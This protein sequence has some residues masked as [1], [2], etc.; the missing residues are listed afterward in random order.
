MSVL[1][2]DIPFDRWVEHVFDHP[3]LPDRWWFHFDDD[4]SEE[5]NT[6]ANPARTLAFLTR[7]LREPAFLIGKYSRA[8]ID[9]G[10]NYLVDPSCSNHMG[11]IRDEALPLKDRRACIEAMT[12]L[13]SDLMAPVYGNDLG[14]TET[15]PGDPERP[16]YA[17]YMWWDVFPLYGGLAHPEIKQLTDSV[18]RVFR[19]S[20]TLRSEAC[21]ESTLHG[22]GH[23]QPYVPKQIKSMIDEFLKSRPKLRPLLR[24]YAQQAAEGL[25]Q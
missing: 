14:H 5:W 23:W 21:L 16:N 12:T 3:V 1:P 25:V 19:Q 2:D 6:E 7:L 17:C 22:C 4:F 18:L 11:V 10:L 15:V 9:Q 20:L 13:N 8:Q 24:Q